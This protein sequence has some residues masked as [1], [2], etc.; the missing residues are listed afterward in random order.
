MQLNTLLADPLFSLGVVILDN[1]DSGIV[2][3]PLIVISS[4]IRLI[5]LSGSPPVL[6]HSRFVTCCTSAIILVFRPRYN[7]GGAENM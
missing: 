5:Q 2:I 1:Y 3:E 7:S 6:A 4:M